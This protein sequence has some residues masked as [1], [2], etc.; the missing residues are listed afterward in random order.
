MLA[1]TSPPT[2]IYGAY[3]IQQAVAAQFATRPTVRS[4]VTNLLMQQLTQ[5]Y[6]QHAFDV[7]K[8]YVV[9]TVDD[10][11]KALGSQRY[12]LLLDVLLEHVATGTPLNYRYYRATECFVAMST[13][14]PPAAGFS[15]IE[16]MSK[17]EPLLLDVSSVWRVALQDALINYWNQPGNTGIDRLHWLARM[18][19]DQLRHGV[20][21]SPQQSEETLAFLLQ[22]LNYPN[23][24]ERMSKSTLDRR[25]KVYSVATTFVKEQTFHVLSSDI[26]IERVE[27]RVITYCHCK[28]NGA[29]EW[30]SVLDQFTR[31]WCAAFTAKYVLKS[32]KCELYEPGSNFLDTQA[33]CILERQLDAI[34]TLNRP[35]TLDALER[36]VALATDPTAAFVINGQSDPVDLTPVHKALPDWLREA[37]LADRFA[38]RSHLIALTNVHKQAQGKRFNDDVSDLYTYTA[39]VLNEH[40]LMDQPQ[41]PGYHAD[42]LLLTFVDPVGPGG[43]GT[44]GTLNK[45]T[46]T[47]TELAI[48]NLTAVRGSRMTISHAKGQLIQTWWMTPEYIK[49]LVTR[50]NIGQHYPQWIFQRL[51]GNTAEAQRREKL[52]SEELRELLPLQALECKIRKTSYMTEAG[53]QMIKALMHLVAEDRRV[54]DMG[55]AIRPLALISTPSQPVHAV[56][57]MFVIGPMAVNAGRHVLY[58]PLHRE[59]LIEYPSW[60]ALFAGIATP[61]AVQKSVLEWLPETARRLFEA[62]GFYRMNLPS[63]GV[64]EDFAFAMRAGAAKLSEF[65]LNADFLHTLY[66]DM[67]RTLAKLAER[68]SVSNAEQRWQSMITGGWLLFSATVPNLPLT[69]PLRLLVGMTFTY[70]AVQKD[71]ETLRSGDEQSKASSIIDLLFNCALVLLHLAPSSAR[72]VSSTEKVDT[73]LIPLA[74]DAKVKDLA[75]ATPAKIDITNSHSLDVPVGNRQTTLEFSW[76]NN[77]Q[78]KFT[79]WQLDWLANNRVVLDR[80]ELTAV[81]RGMFKGLYNWKNEVYADVDKA[82][83]RVQL[84]NDDLYLVNSKKPLDRGPRIVGDDNGVWTFDVRARLL[85]GGPKSRLALKKEQRAKRFN[86]LKEQLT[87]YNV[88]TKVLEAELKT[89]QEESNNHFGNNAIEL[90][91]ARRAALENLITVLERQKP[92]YVAALEK[93]QE[94]QTL[95]PQDSDISNLSGFYKYLIRH[96]SSLYDSCV[97]QAGVYQLEHPDIFNNDGRFVRVDLLNSATYRADCQAMVETLEKAANYFKELTSYVQKLRDLPKVGHKAAIEAYKEF[98][99]DSS[100]YYRSA[101]MC[102]AN[103]LTAFIDL[104]VQP[105]G[106]DAWVNLRQILTALHYTGNSQ[107]ELENRDLF[108]TAERTEILKDIR[109][110]YARAEDRLG[111]FHEEA[112]SQ[113]HLPTYERVLSVIRELDQMAE[114]MLH[115]HAKAESEWLPAQAAPARVPQY[116]RKI[117]RTHKSGI[118]IGKAR[119]GEGGADIADVGGAS[120]GQGSHSGATSFMTVTFKQTAP[121]QWVEVQAPATASV[122]PLSVLKTEANKLIENANAQVNRVK[123]YG[124]RSKFPLELEEILDRYA[125]NLD[126]LVLEIKK[127]AP[128]QPPVENPRPGTVP[129]YLKRLETSAR[130][131][132]EQAISILWSLPPVE[133]TV[134]SL[135]ERQ[136]LSIVKINARIPMQGERQDFVQEYEIKNTDNRV[137]WY[138]HLHYPQA[139]TPSQQVNTAHF[140]LASQRYLSQRAEDAKAKPGRPPVHVHYGSISA[141]MLTNRFLSLDAM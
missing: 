74:E 111:V 35:F 97:L 63:L 56:S 117:I 52:F 81:E 128:D 55:I 84:D 33:M 86:E 76:F 72:P 57:G 17:I 129:M 80:R 122:R 49:N 110:R 12:R 27:G 51:L 37:S 24:N 38:Y 106:S 46:L 44:V 125:Q 26:L 137:L 96:T 115:E 101:V 58:R 8:T 53:Y 94:M 19:H 83:Y 95:S 36:Q 93:F 70:L 43:E 2:P 32:V 42:D 109:E 29:I 89:A 102:R 16:P 9:L 30:F 123:S 103:Q 121:N 135:L 100:T 65:A 45:Y 116:T 1:S 13:S 15:S 7:S 18:I 3:L 66:E 10:Q 92:E 23:R 68:Q 75:A 134:E 141:S 28:A 69:W 47:L 119:T 127:A 25:T 105:P 62:G 41:A 20:S 48:E 73:G 79:Q 54:G 61:G 40:M 138:A 124:K 88:R 77:P 114:A 6:S 91:P 31:A 107:H 118:L 85:G 113:L 132:R 108:S 98:V 59:P 11:G 112:K 133:S 126:K 64:H 120:E 22:V 78:I 39:K 50:V 140:K 104:A 87:Q 21:L 4:V 90:L 99:G 67:S 34:S 5:A 82:L 14:V 71:I 139:N 130:Y 136:K 131:L 60:A